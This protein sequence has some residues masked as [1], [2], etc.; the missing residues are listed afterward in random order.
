MITN[1]EKTKYVSLFRYTY[2]GGGAED[3]PEDI[4]VNRNL[5]VENYSIVKYYKGP[6]RDRLKDMFDHN[7]DHLEMYRTELGQI[8]GVCSNYDRI[9]PS[10]LNMRPAPA[11]YSHAATTY[12]KVWSSTRSL[13]KHISGLKELGACGELYDIMKAAPNSEVVLKDIHG[14]MD[15]YQMHQWN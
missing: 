7:L 4:Y 13:S 15:P 2:W 1:A 8:V 12:V 3:T 11:L 5:F 14:K 6:Y 9:P 10:V